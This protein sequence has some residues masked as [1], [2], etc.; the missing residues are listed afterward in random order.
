MDRLNSNDNE[1]IVLGDRC[2]SEPHE[3]PG[4]SAG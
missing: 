3:L 4:G 2:R 1:N